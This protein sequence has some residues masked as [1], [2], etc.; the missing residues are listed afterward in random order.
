MVWKLLWDATQSRFSV[1]LPMQEEITN[2]LETYGEMMF[3]GENQ[4]TINSEGFWRLKT[5]EI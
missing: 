3:T 1:L 4:G 2:T 5:S